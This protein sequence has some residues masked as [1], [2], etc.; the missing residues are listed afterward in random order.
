LEV[1]A[2][3][4]R[5]SASGN[6]PLLLVHEV[7]EHSPTCWQTRPTIMEHYTVIAPDKPGCG[8]SAFG[9][10]NNYTALAGGQDLLAVLDVG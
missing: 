9:T 10:S 6:P 1:T 7:P 4:F 3:A 2:I 5:Y 8:D